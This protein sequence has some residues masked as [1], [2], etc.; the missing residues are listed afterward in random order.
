[1]TLSYRAYI[2][3]QTK[4]INAMNLKGLVL[5]LICFLLIPIN[6][7][8]IS[9]VNDNWNDCEDLR[10][11]TSPILSQ[12]ENTIYIYTEKQ[13]DN[14]SIEIKDLSGKVVYSTVTTIPAE[15]E[16]PTTI[17]MLPQGEYFF[18][19]TQGSKYI[20]AKFIK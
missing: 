16:Y 7:F 11:I 8:S 17:N 1:M 14:L 15:T 6:V 13:L 2:C 5:G 20:I 18:T 10:S 4:T 3:P 12:D 19:I 9:E